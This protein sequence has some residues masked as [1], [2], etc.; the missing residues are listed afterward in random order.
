MYT[1]EVVPH[2]FGSVLVINA[3]LGADF[4]VKSTFG[5]FNIPLSWCLYSEWASERTFG[6]FLHIQHKQ[7]VWLSKMGTSKPNLDL[8][9]KAL[10]QVW[11]Q[12]RF[13]GKPAAPVQWRGVQEW[14]GDS[15]VEMDGKAGAHCASCSS[16]IVVRALGVITTLGVHNF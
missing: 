2:G 3:I 13:K 12:W 9:T 8:G 14:A 10:W 1:S 5:M 15:P 16:C 11:V 6:N 7:V 4:A